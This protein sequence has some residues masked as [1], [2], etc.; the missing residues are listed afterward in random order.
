MEIEVSEKKSRVYETFVE[1]ASNGLADDALKTFILDRF[2]GIPPKKIVRAAALAL[3]DDSL[4]DKAALQAILGVAIRLRVEG[5]SEAATPAAAV[6]P[7]KTAKA[8]AKD[9]PKA[10][11]PKAGKSKSDKPKAVKAVSQKAAK[12]AKAAKTPKKPVPTAG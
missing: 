11:K 9:K 3:D 12:P 5:A 4:T 2:P 1:G 6:K 10:A 7:A 8:A